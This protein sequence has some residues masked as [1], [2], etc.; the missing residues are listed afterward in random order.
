MSAS[1]ARTQV[2]SPGYWHHWSERVVPCDD[3]LLQ[4][5]CPWHSCTKKCHAFCRQKRTRQF[6]YLLISLVPSLC[7]NAHY[8]LLFFWR[9][10]GS[11]K[12]WLNSDAK[13]QCCYILK[14]RKVETPFHGFNIAASILF[15]HLWSH[16]RVRFSCIVCRNFRVVQANDA[17]VE[18]KTMRQ[19]LSN[20]RPCRRSLSLR[21]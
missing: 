14:N 12:D 15:D 6:K 1:F 18:I 4:I 8:K 9:L 13:M 5:R 10:L 3:C 2:F 11:N 7:A 19:H 21:S 16:I 17:R 20:I